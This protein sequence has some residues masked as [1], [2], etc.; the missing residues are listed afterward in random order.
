MSDVLK[1][2][3]MLPANSELMKNM[4]IKDIKNKNKL[5]DAELEVFLK[6]IEEKIEAFDGEII[7]KNEMSSGA[8]KY[9]KININSLP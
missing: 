8:M 2:Y 7:S 5:S 1:L 9:Y 3:S 6:Y 4:K